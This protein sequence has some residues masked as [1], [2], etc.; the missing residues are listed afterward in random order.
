MNNHLRNIKRRA[1][2]DQLKQKQNE[3]CRKTSSHINEH[4]KGPPINVIHQSSLALK[5]VIC[6][7]KIDHFMT[8]V[9][10]RQQYLQSFDLN[11][12]H[13][14]KQ[15]GGMMRS[16]WIRWWSTSWI[17]WGGYNS[18]LGA[19]NSARYP[20]YLQLPCQWIRFSFKNMYSSG[21]PS[22][23]TSSPMAYDL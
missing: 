13:D 20:S 22:K 9:S 7:S 4:Q 23:S 12:S 1:R 19:L 11:Q 5:Q 15:G 18:S 17:D 10:Q 6:G 3:S 16:C 8:T 21:E 2:K 14:R